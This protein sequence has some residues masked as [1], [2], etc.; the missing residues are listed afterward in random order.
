MYTFLTASAVQLLDLLPFSEQ[1]LTLHTSLT[2]VNVT[3]IRKVAKRS[4]EKRV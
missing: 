2:F 3:E 1:S 4:E